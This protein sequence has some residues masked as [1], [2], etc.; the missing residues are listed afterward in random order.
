[1]QF[2]LVKIIKLII[3]NLFRYSLVSGTK[4]FFLVLLEKHFA[5]FN[6]TAVSLIYNRNYNYIYIFPD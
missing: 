5:S 3:E 4:H 1:M 2:C 6:F